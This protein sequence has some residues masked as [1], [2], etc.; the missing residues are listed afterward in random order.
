MCS[1]TKP[2]I[3]RALNRQSVARRVPKTDQD[4][5]VFATAGQTRVSGT[6]LSSMPELS[7]KCV[8]VLD[9]VG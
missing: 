6:D 1:E 7:L 3:K 4:R 9:L 2:A 8:L 5:I